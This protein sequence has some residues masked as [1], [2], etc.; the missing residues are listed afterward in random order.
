VHAGYTLGLGKKGQRPPASVLEPF[1]KRTAIAAADAC[2]PE[3]SIGK[4]RHSVQN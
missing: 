2:S 1:R 4:A 3:W